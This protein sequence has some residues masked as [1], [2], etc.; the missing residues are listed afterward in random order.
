MMDTHIYRL[1]STK[2]LLAGFEELEAQQIY[3]CPPGDL[4]D[5]VE[6][7]KDLLWAGD[8]IVWRNFLKHYVLCLLHVAPAC[9]AGGADFDRSVLRNLVFAV[10]DELPP[11]PLRT[12]YARV[13]EAFLNDAAVE[14]FVELMAA[15]TT[16]IRRNE[17]THY[18]RSLHALALSAVFKEFEDHGLNLFRPGTVMPNQEALRKNAIAM[19]E[20]ASK[21]PAVKPELN[22]TEAYFSAS[23]ATVGQLDLIAEYGLTDRAA[24]RPMQFFCRYYPPSYVD[25][26]DRLVHPDWYVACFSA[27]PTNASMWGSYGDGHRGVGLKFRTTPNDAGSPA[28]RLNRVTSLGGGKGDHVYGWSFVPHEFHEVKYSVRHPEID[29]FRSLGAVSLM[30]LNH[31]WYL[32]DN[33]EF[34]SC[35]QT[36]FHDQGAKD[37]Y[38]MTFQES[39]LVKTSEWAHEKEYRLVLHSGFDIREKPM[40]ALEYKFE[41]LVGVIF[42]ARTDIEDK[43]EVMR[44]IDRKCA[45]E[46]R[47]DFEFWE[48]RYSNP[49]AKFNLAKLDLL[50][51]KHE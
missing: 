1:R 24:T 4:N 32:G 31:F 38:W 49:D 2:Q 10:P 23:E 11:T 44:I 19:M 9:F 28:L 27:N 46:H 47:S 36:A 22:A 6:G 42:G 26:L 30:N 12:I 25:A 33:G 15:R 35:R 8:T 51:I 5:P 39:A 7:F 16:P 14:R 29:F 45:R 40:R 17:L 21:L 20:A 3:F 18:L 41:D 50:K 37:E 34:S 13:V 43:L 48:V